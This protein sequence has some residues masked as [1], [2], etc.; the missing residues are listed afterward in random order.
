MK[1]LYL[2]VSDN[3]TVD[4]MT[5]SERN[6]DISARLDALLMNPPKIELPSDWR[7]ETFWI[8]L[9]TLLNG[10]QSMPSVDPAMEEFLKQLESYFSDEYKSLIEAW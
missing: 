2:Q 8:E 10:P 1:T 3:Y 4:W 6:R 5:L 9:L 7:N